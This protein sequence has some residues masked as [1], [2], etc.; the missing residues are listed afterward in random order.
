MSLQN[1]ENKMSKSDDNLNNIISLLDSPSIIRK[2]IKRAVTDSGTNIIFDEK[3]LGLAN[4]MTIYS[5]ATG[6]SISQIEKNY[7]G[8]MYSDFKADL[9]DVLVEFLAPI[10]K[11]YELLMKDKKHIQDILKIGS[12]KATFKAYKTLDKVYRKIGLLKK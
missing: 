8:K 7:K 5:I 2:K 10:Q 12:E 9:G 6:E 4:L 3:R 11:E 1:P